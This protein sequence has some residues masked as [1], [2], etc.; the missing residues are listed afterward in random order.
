MV[1]TRKGGADHG[2]L[3]R[4]NRQPSQ[5]GFMATIVALPVRSGLGKSIDKVV[6]RAQAAAD[7]HYR[8]PRRCPPRHF[9]CCRDFSHP[10]ASIIMGLGLALMWTPYFECTGRT[11][12]NPNLAEHHMRVS[13]DALQ[14]DVLWTDIPAARSSSV[15]ANR[16]A[17]RKTCFTGWATLSAVRSAEPSGGREPRALSVG[18]D[19]SGD[20]VGYSCIASQGTEG[21][22]HR[23]E[24]P[25]GR[26]RRVGRRH[27]GNHDLSYLSGC[28]QAGRR[29]RGWNV[30]RRAR[31]EGSGDGLQDTARVGADQTGLS[32][33]RDRGIG[34]RGRRR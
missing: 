19:W 14:I 21:P 9:P 32:Q 34:G 18:G 3:P 27:G 31:H 30:L 25:V 8:Q 28:A 20:G 12:V 1:S 13:M 5:K 4:R 26:I 10:R 24:S 22:E 17:G 7:Y 15:S 33:G 16:V 23:L 2:Y 11:Q 29:G 6:D